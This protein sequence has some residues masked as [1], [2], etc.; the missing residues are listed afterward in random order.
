M[1]LVL[2]RSE[3]FRKKVYKKTSKHEGDDV[4]V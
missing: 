4:N 3:P 1:A 2:M